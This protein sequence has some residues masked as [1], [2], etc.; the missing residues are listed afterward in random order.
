MNN[1]ISPTQRSEPFLKWAGGKR[2]LIK[3]G[4]E[5]A[6]DSYRV[7]I[8]P[9]VGS[10]AVFFSQEPQSAILADLNSELVIVYQQL[11]SNWQA[12][13]ETLKKHS[14]LH[15]DSYY[16]KI[17]ASKPRL[18]H[19]IA[20]RFIYLNRTCWNGLYRVNL[21]GEFNV[22]RGTKNSVLLDTDDFSAVA[23]SLE[24]SEVLCQ[25]FSTTIASA[26]NNDFVFVD[27]PY[28]VNHNLNG[29]LKYNE[30]I[31]SWD[32]QIRLRDSIAEAVER[33]AKVTMTNADHPSI[34]KLYKGMGEVEKLF[35]NSVIAGDSRHRK[36]TSEV[37][38]RFGWAAS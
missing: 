24:S 17:R 10:G 26:D 22:P 31:F 29:F 1:I 18:P 13:E 4:A 11:K 5:I 23:K 34:R 16:Y 2:W 20:A 14:R 36:S 6:P 30:K 21:K 8:E 28:T 7:Y 12:V 19:T 15:N 35:R 32:D 37:L 27:P 38:I 9:F 25:D 3:S 33:G